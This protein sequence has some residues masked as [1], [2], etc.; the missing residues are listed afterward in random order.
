MQRVRPTKMAHVVYRTRRFAEMLRWYELV[1]DT[2]VQYQNPGLAF[3]TFDG[4]HH[5]FAFANLEL[6]QPGGTEADRQGAIGVDHVGYTYGSLHDLFENYAQLK[7]QGIV[8]YWCIHH[9]MT[10]SMYYTDPDGNQMEFQV[11]S[12]DSGEAASEFMNTYF[13]I[14]PLGVEYDPEVWLA[15][16]RAGTDEA[17]LLKRSGHEPVSPL[18]GAFARIIGA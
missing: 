9:G 16:L 1:F 14:N 10:V 8:P 15:L 6:F 7:E 17:E 18:R 5:R 4:E 3:L 2:T 13:Q 12:F 11:D